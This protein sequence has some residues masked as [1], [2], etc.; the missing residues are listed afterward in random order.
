MTLEPEEMRS[1]DQTV[2]AF[3]A[4]FEENDRPDGIDQQAPP[5]DFDGGESGH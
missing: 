5:L 3:R 4:F 1:I 2:S